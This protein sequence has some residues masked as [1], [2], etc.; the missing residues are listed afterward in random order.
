MVDWL[1]IWL[2]WFRLPYEVKL[3]QHKESRNLEDEDMKNFVVRSRSVKHMW[4][5]SPVLVFGI[6]DIDTVVQLQSVAQHI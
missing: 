1:V 5:W 6:G 3:N 4:Q 2:G